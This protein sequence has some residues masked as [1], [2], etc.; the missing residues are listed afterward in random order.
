[1][2]RIGISAEYEQAGSNHCLPTITVGA[3]RVAP[4]PLCLHAVANTPA[5]PRKR[6]RSLHLGFAHPLP[7]EDNGSTST[8]NMAE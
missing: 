6:I 7:Q 1:M 8:H 4:H 5:S 2:S 3:S